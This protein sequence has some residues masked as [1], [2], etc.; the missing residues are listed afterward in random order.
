[1]IVD[2][3]VQNYLSIKEKQ[4]LS[5]EADR[6]LRLEDPY[7]MEV[8]GWRLLKLG[9][10][11]GANA[12]GKTN[13][14]QAMELLK[15]LV[16]RPKMNKNDS[17]DVVPFLFDE[18]T[19][20]ENTF[21]SIRF[22]QKGVLYS[23]EVELNKDAVINESLYF[24]DPRKSL[25]FNRTTDTVKKL[26]VITFG[27]KIKVEKSSIDEL[28][29]N[30]LWNNTTLG[31]FL[32]TNADINQLTEVTDWFVSYLQHVI[33]PH[34]YLDSFVTERLDKQL[35]DKGLLLRLLNK[36]DFGIS[37]LII[38]NEDIEVNDTL[39][40]I[41]RSQRNM[42]SEALNEMKR[43]GKITQVKVAVEHTVGGKKYILP[44]E[45]ESQGTE[46]YY[47]LS[48]ILALLIGGSVIISIDELEGSLHPDLFEHFLLTFLLNAKNSQL[49][50][51]THYRE[52]LNKKDFFRNDA[53]WFTER[54]Q[55]SA[56][57]LYSLTDFDSSVVRDTT[58]VYNAYKMGKFG[59]IPMLKDTYLDVE[60]HEKQ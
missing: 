28:T 44:F 16:I 24:N 15:E 18:K 21:I 53:I 37:D 14:L 29:K 36:A 26:A 2:F 20:S 48:G 27:P 25:V 58:N 33:F 30:T 51:T 41:L 31:G 7:V 9:L 47:G 46:R 52:I 40:E 38:R 23:Y 55:Q 32:K 3:S 57:E 19:P 59:A 43:N 50:A 54:N 12:S 6:S 45:A 56:T 4:T 39:I 5:F 17:L 10:I 42:P 60:S 49:L 11:Y 13:V 34:V 8:G 35:V 1:M 22:I